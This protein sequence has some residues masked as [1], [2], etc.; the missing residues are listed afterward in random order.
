MLEKFP[1]K[2]GTDKTKMYA[3][4]STVQN[5]TGTHRAIDVKVNKSY[6]YWKG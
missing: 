1:L 3:L 2:S 6:E 5:C 4:S